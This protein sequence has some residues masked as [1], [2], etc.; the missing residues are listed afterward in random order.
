MRRRLCRW[1]SSLQHPSC[2]VS[3]HKLTRVAWT[4]EPHCPW[5]FHAQRLVKTT[6]RPRKSQPT[7]IFWTSKLLLTE[8]CNSFHPCFVLGHK[9]LP[10]VPLFL[11]VKSARHSK[12]NFWK[13]QPLACVLFLTS[14]LVFT[15][16]LTLTYRS[17]TLWSGENCRVSVFMVIAPSSF[18][19]LRPVRRPTL[20]TATENSSC[21]VWLMH[22]E[23]WMV[24]FKLGEK[25][26]N[27]FGR[28]CRQS[29]LVQS[30]L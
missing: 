11:L 4:D 18:L 5:E 3:L 27:V 21:K 20:G 24:F 15:Q 1:I 30:F 19:P 13:T 9:T 26:P 10:C 29:H 16:V 22:C 12:Q 25:A 8:N 28:N 14:V 6:N 23:H 7:P 17:Q 2:A